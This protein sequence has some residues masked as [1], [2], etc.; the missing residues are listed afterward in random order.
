MDK[1]L[2]SDGKM[3]KDP[4]V[5]EPWSITE[6]KS[7]GRSSRKISFS[8]SRSRSNAREMTTSNSIG[9]SAGQS[10]GLFGG[11]GNPLESASGNSTREEDETDL[12]WAALEKLPTYN[13][14]RTSILQKHTGSVREVDVKHLSM[15]DFNHLLQTLHKPTANDEQQLFA[16]M[17]KRLDRCGH[18]FR[19]A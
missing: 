14:I 12:R 18:H 19:D 13:R 3:D 17:R 5:G 9:P 8:L 6:S 15:A 16:K 1:D 7:M 11:S 4:E 2:E 10:Y